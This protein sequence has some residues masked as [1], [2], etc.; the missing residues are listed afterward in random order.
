[1]HVRRACGST[2][3]NQQ[4]ALAG[5]L[6]PCIFHAVAFNVNQLGGNWCG[7]PHRWTHLGTRHHIEL[8]GYFSIS[9]P[10]QKAMCPLMLWAAGFG[11][12]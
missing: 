5:F 7:S 6:L 12:G 1:M 10:R 9:T 11:F 3:G 4:S 8:S 2:W